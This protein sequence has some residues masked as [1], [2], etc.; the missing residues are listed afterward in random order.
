M[1][2]VTEQVVVAVVQSFSHVQLCIPTD[3]STPGFPVLHHLPEVAQIQAHWVSD[4]IQ[5]SLP[6][7]SP[8]PPA[9]NLSQ[10]QSGTGPI[11]KDEPWV[12]SLLYLAWNTGVLA[13]FYSTTSDSNAVTFPSRST[14]VIGFSIIEY[15]KPKPWKRQKMIT[16][17]YVK[18][19]SH[20]LF[21]FYIFVFFPFLFLLFTGFPGS[22]FLK[23]SDLLHV[24]EKHSQET[25]FRT[26][27]VIQQVRI[28]LPMQG[29]WVQSLVREL[30]S[31]M[32]C[33]QKI[34]T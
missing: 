26:S 15:S 1:V 27:L 6:L 11:L 10:H 22:N 31:R 33:S 23:S 14:I 2:P 25:E 21:Y 32:P 28:H 12:I 29:V 3:C 13:P 8:S 5:T 19:D 16:L 17:N 9:F 18:L 30:R 20:G 4:A 24:T 7:S 34:K